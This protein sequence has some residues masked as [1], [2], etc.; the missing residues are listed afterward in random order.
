M[1]AKLALVAAVARLRLAGIEDPA[2]DARLLLAHAMMLPPERLTLH[3]GD[4]LPPEAQS[5]F[6]AAVTA[7]LTRQ[8]V[9]QILGHRLF[10]SRRFIVTADTLDPRPETEVLI[11]EAL[12]APFQRLLDIGTGT[13]A[14]LLTLL[15][16]RPEARGLGTDIS[17]AALAVAAR[18]AQALGLQDRASFQTSDWLSGVAGSFDLIVSNPPYIALDE[19]AD[20]APEVRD[21]EPHLALTDG[22]D[23]LQAYRALAAQVPQALAPGGRL[24]LEIGPS[25][26]RAVADLLQAA[27]LRDVA[28]VTDLDGRDRVVSAQAQAE[29]L[30]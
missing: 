17:A 15:A 27:G 19:M 23:G 1:I 13:G 12:Q 29:V 11:A 24:L 7:R 26:G 9:S 10:Y 22:H 25:Q 21:H 4:A 14:I 30:K 20:L 5:R 2:R 8:P 3:M 6:E 28:V 18:N 16:E